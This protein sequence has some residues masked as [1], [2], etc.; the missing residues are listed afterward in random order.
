MFKTVLISPRFFFRLRFTLKFI[1]TFI[2][3]S[4][5]RRIIFTLNYES[6]NMSQNWNPE[7]SHETLTIQNTAISPEFCT[8]SIVNENFFTEDPTFNR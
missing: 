8:Q 4:A 6:L 7:F 3:P 5:Y 2:L 1:E